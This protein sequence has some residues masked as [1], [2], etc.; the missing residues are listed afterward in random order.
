MSSSMREVRLSAR[1]CEQAERLYG[2]RF[3]SVENF[4]TH[5]LERLVRDDANQMDQEEQRMIEERLKDLGYI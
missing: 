1:L 5:V 3:A 4:L 2:E